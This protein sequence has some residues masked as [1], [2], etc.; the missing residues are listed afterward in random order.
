MGRIM[1]ARSVTMFIAAL[2]NHMMNWSIHR[3]LGSLVQK[4]D[5]GTKGHARVSGTY[6]FLLHPE[7]THHK[8][9]YFQ[10]TSISHR[11]RQRP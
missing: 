9:I 8:Q 3:A 6:A 10:T 7:Q 2:K 4:A 5:I 1:I 11:R